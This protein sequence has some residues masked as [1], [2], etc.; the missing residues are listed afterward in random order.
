MSLPPICDGWREQYAKRKPEPQPLIGQGDRRGISFQFP[1]SD[2]DDGFPRLKSGPFK[3]R[4]VFSGR[5]EAQEIAK[6]M[7]DR[8]ETRITY[9]S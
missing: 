5:R 9:D 6:R 3:G 4:I 8:C 2:V 1:P 7:A